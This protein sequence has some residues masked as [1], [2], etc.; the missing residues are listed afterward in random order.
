MASSGKDTLEKI[1]NDVYD[2]DNEVLKCE[3]S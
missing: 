2:E 3:V 1:L